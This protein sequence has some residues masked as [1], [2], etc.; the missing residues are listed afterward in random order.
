M[1]LLTCKDASR[2]QSQA[3]DRPLRF[4]ERMGL[5]LH[6]LICD[7]CRRFKLQLDLIRRACRQVN[8][9]E[10]R[11]VEQPGLAPEAKARI[12][13]ELASKQSDRDN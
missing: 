5:R 8:E 13:K 2:L 3:Q 12:L 1:K 9:S 6:L 4:G 11:G 10:R 7:N